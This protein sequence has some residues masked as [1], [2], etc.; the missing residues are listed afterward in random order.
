[1]AH[2]GSIPCS[3]DLV[4]CS[5]PELDESSLHHPSSTYIL[6][7]FYHLCLSLPCGPLF[8]VPLQKTHM[9]FSALPYVTCPK[10]KSWISAP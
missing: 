6:I 1:M 7:L 3:H 8:Q 10:L 5:C 4:T 2:V 9:H